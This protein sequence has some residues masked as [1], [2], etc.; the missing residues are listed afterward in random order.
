[1]SC[2]SLYCGIMFG[3]DIEYYIIHRPRFLLT[4]IQYYYL[5]IVIGHRYT[6]TLNLK[7]SSPIQL[8]PSIIHSL[9]FTL[10]I[11]NLLDVSV[12]LS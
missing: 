2:D 6:A 3:L 1:M 5:A 9:F 8:L 4:V 10:R 11:C 7:Y 12:I